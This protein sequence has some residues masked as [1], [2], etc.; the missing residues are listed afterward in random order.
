MLGGTEV[1]SKSSRLVGALLVLLASS[2]A[3]SDE[4]FV[5]AT[6]AKAAGYIFNTDFAQ[7]S[8]LGV[9][10]EAELAVLSENDAALNSM[11][12]DALSM[13]ES[14]GGARLAAH[15]ELEAQITLLRFRL[16]RP[17]TGHYWD[18]PD[19]S[20]EEAHLNDGQFVYHSEYLA[21]IE[22]ASGQPIYEAAQPTESEVQ[23]LVR[24]M[25]D[26]SSDNYYWAKWLARKLRLVPPTG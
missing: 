25:A 26:P 10:D 24:L 1:I 16:F 23:E 6:F 20:S 22:A 11:I 5:A 9:F 7:G 18:G 17:G 13:S 14:V 4:Q 3:Q 2:T 12:R 19:Y 15:F 8:V 21:A